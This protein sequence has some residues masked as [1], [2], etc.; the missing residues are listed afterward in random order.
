MTS[1]TPQ[2]RF[3]LEEG[4]Q[5]CRKI[6]RKHFPYDVHDYSIDVAAKI[7]DQTDVLVRTACASG[8]TG[9][10]ALIAVI[11]AEVA[12][13]DTL[14]P[15]FHPWYEKNPAL[16][17]ICPTDALE[18]NMVRVLWTMSTR[19]KHIEQGSL[20]R[21]DDNTWNQLCSPQF[22]SHR[23]RKSWGDCRRTVG[24]G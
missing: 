17:V 7:M 13:D 11:M 23:S 3:Y 21:Q 12:A 24:K 20:G 6:A 2:F 10:I 8:K 15:G 22:G 16:L 5:L 19:L 18:V 4:R 9:T 1:S 14:A